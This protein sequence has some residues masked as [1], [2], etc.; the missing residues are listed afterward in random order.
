MKKLSILGSTGSIGT[1]TLEVVRRHPERFEVVALACGHNIELLK[2]QIEEFK[3]SFVAVAEESDA[4]NLALE[5]PDIKV[6]FGSLGIINAASETD[7]TM[8]VN[9]LMGMIGFKPTVYAIQAGKDIA[10]A[11]KET[12]VS[13]G[14]VVMKMAKENNV[15]IL[16]IDSEHSA[17]FQC[18]QGAGPN[19]IKRILLTA[20]GGPFRG[21]TKEQLKDV[22][23]EQALKHPNWSM[24]SKIT[25]DS[26]TLMN[27]GLEVIE[28]ATLFGVNANQIQVVVHPESAIHSAIEFEDGS[29]IAQIGV[30]D[31]KIPIAYALTYPERLDDVSVPLN[32]FDLATMHFEKPDRHTFEC[33][34]L[35]Y[36]AMEHGLSYRVVL[37]AANEIAVEAFLKGE[38]TFL[39]IPEVINKACAQ[40]RRVWIESPVGILAVDDNTRQFARRIIEQIKGK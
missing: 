23:V 22:T 26:A 29:I 36:K 11:N 13:G 14:D 30:P 17:I 15:Q 21:Y 9:A 5:Y 35:A 32:L 2:K 18:L 8:V 12:L 19:K 37:N 39:Q 3:P 6:E 4:K 34:D 25:I 40:H 16:P 20:S 28:A 7:C 31:M 24:G 33:L 38:I 27:K 10:L 1:Q